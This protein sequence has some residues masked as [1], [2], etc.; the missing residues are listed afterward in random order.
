MKESILIDFPGV[1]TPIFT[2]FFFHPFRGP[3]ISREDTVLIWNSYG[4]RFVP[5]IILFFRYHCSCISVFLFQ[6]ERMLECDWRGRWHRLA[7]TPPWLQE[8]FVTYQH[9]LGFWCEH[10][11]CSRKND[12]WL[13]SAFLHPCGAQSHSPTH[14]HWSGQ[15][16]HANLPACVFVCRLPFKVGHVHTI[17]ASGVYFKYIKCEKI[18]EAYF[19]YLGYPKF[20]RHLSKL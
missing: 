3:H 2:C 9:G 5:F 6:I 7:A 20:I 4:R 17:V 15:C 19:T 12:K 13:R 10:F 11:E 18:E 1:N 8:K 16:H 14:T